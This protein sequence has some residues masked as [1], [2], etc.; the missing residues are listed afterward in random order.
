MPNTVAFSRGI[1][2][3]FFFYDCVNLQSV[4]VDAPSTPTRFSKGALC[5][6]DGIVFCSVAFPTA[7]S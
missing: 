5:D 3:K 2:V 6:S 4:E 1:L 7:F